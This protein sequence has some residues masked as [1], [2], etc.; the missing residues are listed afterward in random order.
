M[1]T[2]GHEEATPTTFRSSHGPI[3]A[4]SALEWEIYEHLLEAAHS[5]D[6]EV[7]DREETGT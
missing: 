1:R 5:R 3:E 2:Q 7:Q 6:V 4:W